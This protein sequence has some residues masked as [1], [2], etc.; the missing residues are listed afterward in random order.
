MAPSPFANRAVRRLGEV[1]FG[2]YLIHIPIGLYAVTA[3]GLPRDGSVGA[4]AL[5]SFVI[6]PP[7][8]AYAY[9]SLRLVERPGRRWGRSLECRLTATTAVPIRGEAVRVA[10]PAP[11]E[12]RG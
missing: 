10:A 9:A 8:L 7:A 12:V 11:A 2:L 3:L 5:W 1:S 6:V 4:V